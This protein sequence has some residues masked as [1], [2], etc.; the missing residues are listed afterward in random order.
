[1]LTMS[2]TLKNDLLRGARMIAEEIYPVPDDMSGEERERAQET[3]TRRVY[4]EQHRWPIWSEDGVLF[5]LRS[6][7]HS[8]VQAKS[9]Q[10]EAEIAAAQL[11]GRQ[12]Q[13]K[14]SLKSRRRRAARKAVAA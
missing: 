5:A 10:R 9:R 6:A 11:E 12:P 13:S 1:M 4:N 3:A 14:P 8:H 7:L 2:E